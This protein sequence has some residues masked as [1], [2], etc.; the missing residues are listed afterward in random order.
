M[1]LIP[2]TN[3]IL[4]NFNNDLMCH[5]AFSYTANVCTVNV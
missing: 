1:L 4:N 3:E 5:H 2:D